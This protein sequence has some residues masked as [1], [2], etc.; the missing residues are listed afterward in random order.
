[1]GGQ[2]QVDLAQCV[3]GQLAS[4]LVRKSPAN[5]DHPS[6]ISGSSKERLETIMIVLRF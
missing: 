6:S 4:W 5:A 2:S 3:A 1:M